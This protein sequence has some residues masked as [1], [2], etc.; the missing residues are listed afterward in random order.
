MRAYSPHHHGLIPEAHYHFESVFIPFEI[1]DN[2]IAWKKARR[3]ES[4][5]QIS[6][7]LPFSSLYL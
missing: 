6:G 5:L 3:R 7:R 4:S 2:T 1:E